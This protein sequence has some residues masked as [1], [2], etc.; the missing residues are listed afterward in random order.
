MYT[1]TYTVFFVI[2]VF[3]A[4]LIVVDSNVAKFFLLCIEIIKVNI[5][6]F[7]W[8]IKFHPRVTTNPIFQWWMMRKYMKEAEKIQKEMK[9]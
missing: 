1:S 6:R 7:V 4:Y 9:E 3:A 8:M 2:F 5:E